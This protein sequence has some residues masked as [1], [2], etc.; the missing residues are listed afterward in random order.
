MLFNEKI[1]WNRLTFLEGGGYSQKFLLDTTEKCPRATA[2]VLGTP[3][4]PQGPVTCSG[5]RSEW[6]CWVALARL[7]SRHVGSNLESFLTDTLSVQHWFPG[8]EAALGKGVYFNSSIGRRCLLLRLHVMIWIKGHTIANV[9]SDV[10]TLSNCPVGLPINW[11]LLSDIPFW[12]N[13]REQPGKPGTPPPL[14]PSFLFPTGNAS[15]FQTKCL[16]CPFM[17]DPSTQP[18]AESQPTLLMT[19]FGKGGIRRQNEN[20]HGRRRSISNRRVYSMNAQS[21]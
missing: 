14:D 2:P 9:A 16:S 1:I 18:S 4:L 20:L 7:A 10:L 11:A 15:P 3:G 13:A 12:G 21:H 5:Q 6:T 8:Q 17:A 19:H